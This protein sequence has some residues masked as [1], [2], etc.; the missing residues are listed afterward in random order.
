[1]YRCRNVKEEIK[2]KNNVF[3]RTVEKGV[4][5]FFV[6]VDGKNYFLFRQEYR[7]GV[8]RYFRKGINIDD[9]GD[10]SHADACVRR[11]LDK[12]PIAIK[13][14]EKRNGIA[15]YK[16]TKDRADGKKNGYNRQSFR[17]PDINDWE[18]VA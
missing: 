12:L 3:C 8:G 16:R 15:V 7:R 6:R 13:A 5:A 4:H 18:D 2:M 10:Y 9:L 1:M 11:T 17:K 14:L